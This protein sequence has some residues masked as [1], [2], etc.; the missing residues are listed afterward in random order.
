MSANDRDDLTGSS[1]FA[2][3]QWSMV[4]AAGNTLHD[5]AQVAL[6][7][8]CEAYWFPLYAYARR[9]TGNVDDAREMTQAFFG[10]LLEKNIV[11]RASEERGRF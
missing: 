4:R 9:R 2:S 8:L 6:S 3:T 10:E 1:Q 5:E 11:R 7:Q